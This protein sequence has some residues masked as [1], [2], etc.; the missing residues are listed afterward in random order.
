MI[1]TI[2]KETIEAKK[3]ETVIATK[4]QFNGELIAI[5]K[6]DAQNVPAR[7]FM[8]FDPS[9]GF[10]VC[11]NNVVEMMNVDSVEVD[12]GNYGGVTPI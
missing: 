9:D 1:R 4:E 7:H 3:N 12:G 6:D 5:P 8:F 11:I 2:R 10:C